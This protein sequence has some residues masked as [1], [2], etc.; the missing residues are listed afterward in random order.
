MTIT[1]LK[2]IH[3]DSEK[4]YR[5]RPVLLQ[6]FTAMSDR[7]K[8]PR[9]PTS[10][11]V[12]VLHPKIKDPILG[13]LH[14]ISSS[15]AKIRLMP[16][17]YEDPHSFFVKEKALTEGDKIILSQPTVSNIIYRDIPAEIVAVSNYRRSCIIRLKFLISTKTER[18]NIWIIMRALE[19]QNKLSPE[20]KTQMGIADQ[21]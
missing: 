5:S 16:A 11:V 13:M 9:I 20:E 18:D 15:G 21:D 17:A 6:T 8:E 19:R 10:G 2:E 1:A 7:R 4:K 3:T 14:D 12:G